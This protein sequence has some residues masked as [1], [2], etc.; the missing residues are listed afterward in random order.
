MPWVLSERSSSAPT[1]TGVASPTSASE[2]LKSECP[3]YLKYEVLNEVQQ[4]LFENDRLGLVIPYRKAG[5]PRKYLPDFVVELKNGGPSDCSD[6]GRE[7]DA[8]T[9]K[10]AAERWCRAVGTWAHEICGRSERHQ[11]DSG[12]Q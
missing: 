11:E 7:G 3:K 5:T 2:L 1:S 8:A 4:T 6:Q 9:K 10:V 12:Y